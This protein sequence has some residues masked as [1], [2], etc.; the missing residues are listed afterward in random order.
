MH[1]SLTSVRSR[2][3]IIVS[4]L[5]LAATTIAAEP[6]PLPLQRVVAFTSGIAYFDHVG[7]VQD[8]Q[9]VT[10]RFNVEDIND[11]L[12]RMVARDFD[13]GQVRLSLTK[14]ASRWLVLCGHSRSI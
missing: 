10:L 5:S 7:Q 6:D 2:C 3:A 11:L 8:D 1:Y 9:E 14:H 13:G 4:T 12:K